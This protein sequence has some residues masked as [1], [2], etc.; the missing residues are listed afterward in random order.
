LSPNGSFGRVESFGR[1]ALRGH[2]LPLDSAKRTTAVQ[3]VLTVATG[4]RIYADWHQA[5]VGHCGRRWLEWRLYEVLR[6]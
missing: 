5:V 2:Q 4:G 1:Q 3:R 6:S